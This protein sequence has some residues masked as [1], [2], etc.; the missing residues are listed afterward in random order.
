MRVFDRSAAQIIL[1]NATWQAPAAPASPTGGSTIDSEARAAIDA[2]IIQ[3][4]ASG[5][6]PGT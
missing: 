1:F 4:K 3:L 2:L 6:F 5:V